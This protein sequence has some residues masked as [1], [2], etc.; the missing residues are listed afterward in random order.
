[1]IT[2]AAGWW[3]YSCAASCRRDLSTSADSSSGVSVTPVRSKSRPAPAA[4]ISSLNSAYALPGSVSVRSLARLPTW[5]TPSLGIHT[6]EG[7]KSQPSLF[8]MTRTPS[9]SATAMALLVVPRSI[10]KSMVSR[11]V[12]WSPWWFTGWGARACRR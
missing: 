5:I 2:A 7:V 4:P 1:M 8:L 10:P 3:P 11:M 9:S 12:A 6:A